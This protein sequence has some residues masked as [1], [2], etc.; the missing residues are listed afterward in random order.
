[1]VI[2]GFLL[3]AFS[4]LARNLHGTFLMATM[5]PIPAGRDL[6]HWFGFGNS[7]QV[8]L[9]QKR[10]SGTVYYQVRSHDSMP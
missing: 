10:P 5:V 7:H 9:G 6:F 4:P 3:T 8:A 2:H 1:M